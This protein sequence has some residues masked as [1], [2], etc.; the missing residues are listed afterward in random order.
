MKSL[1]M[2]GVSKGTNV[3]MCMVEEMEMKHLRKPRVSPAEA[4]SS[5][6]TVRYLWNHTSDP[7]TGRWWFCCVEGDA[8][9]SSPSFHSSPQC[10]L[11]W[12]YFLVL[13]SAVFSGC[14]GTFQQTTK[15]SAMDLLFCH[16]V[17]GYVAV[18]TS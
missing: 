15:K 2:L 9:P 14:H 4:L 7:G 1:E 18:N 16:V 3:V 12:C 6:S 11:H 10:Y 8:L 17:S 5:S 13:I